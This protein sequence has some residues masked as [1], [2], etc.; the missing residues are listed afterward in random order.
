MNR[1]RRIAFLGQL[2][3]AVVLLSPSSRADYTYTK[4]EVPGGFGTSAYAINNLGQVV[5]SYSAGGLRHGYVRAS[6]GSYMTFDPMGSSE[7]EVTGINDSG[8]IV[9]YAVLDGVG[10]RGFIRAADGTITLVGNAGTNTF[11]EGINNLGQISGYTQT[12]AGPFSYPESGF[13]RSADG[14]SITPIDF[15]PDATRVYGINDAGKVVVQSTRGGPNAIRNV[16][17]SFINLPFGFSA[18]DI[19]NLGRI[20]GSNNLGASLLNPELRIYTTFNVPGVF[21]TDSL[22]GS[23]DLGQVVGSYRDDVN[24]GNLAFLATPTPSAVPEPASLAMLGVGCVGILGLIRRAR[25]RRAGSA[26]D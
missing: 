5:G 9:G 22:L 19:D 13:I 1:L 4:L 15:D 21:S 26:R 17:G 11:L 24:G 12:Y 23:N 14:M 16:D 25:S 2:V 20:A 8:V 10:I 18:R 3:L 6:D 7:T